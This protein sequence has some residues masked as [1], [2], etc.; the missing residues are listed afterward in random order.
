MDTSRLPTRRLRIFLRDFRVVE[1][2]AGFAE[3]QSLATYFGNR[4]TYLN[5]RA[6]EWA[7]T[8]EKIDHAM[9]RV[10]QVLYVAAPGNDVPLTT[11]SGPTRLVE[12][13]LDGGLRVRGGLLLGARQRLS[14]VLESAGAFIPLTGAQLLRSGRPPKEVNVELGDIVLNQLAIQTVWELAKPAPKPRSRGRASGDPEG[15]RAD[16]LGGL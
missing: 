16:D 13:Q 8:N 3:G 5:L 1:A 10:D 12:M 14:D 2:E 4:R 6:T 15:G 11:A 9:L 7:S